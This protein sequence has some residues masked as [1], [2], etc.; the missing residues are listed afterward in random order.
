MTLNNAHACS[1][2][3]VVAVELEVEQMISFEDYELEP[4]IYVRDLVELLSAKLSN[5]EGDPKAIAIS[6]IAKHADRNDIEIALDT[7]LREVFAAN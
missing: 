6:A 4:L 3:A 5:D 7:R 2:I 1:K